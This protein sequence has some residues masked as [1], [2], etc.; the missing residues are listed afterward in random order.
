MVL[1]FIQLWSAPLMSQIWHV[2]SME[3]YV[4]PI[5]GKLIL[6]EDT[7]KIT[8]AAYIFDKLQMN[9]KMKPC[10]SLEVA[11]L[12]MYSIRVQHLDYGLRIIHGK[13]SEVAK[14]MMYRTCNLIYSIYEG[15]VNVTLSA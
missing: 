3:Q 2:V 11:H 4:N 6:E 5:A 13:D 14:Q 8:S 7:R 9:G 15:Y 12:Y 1:R 10:N